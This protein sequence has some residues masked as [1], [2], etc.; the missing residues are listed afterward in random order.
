MAK[1]CIDC[2]HFK[3]TQEPIKG[4]DWGRAVCKK[5]DLVTDFVTRRNLKALVCVEEDND[6]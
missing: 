3:I 2:P 4:W 1:K 6:G 5:Y